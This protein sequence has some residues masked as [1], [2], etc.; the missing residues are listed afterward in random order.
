MR[1]VLR[2]IP[3]RS[4][5][6]A[7][8]CSIA[9]GGPRPDHPVVFVGDRLGVPEPRGDRTRERRRQFRRPA[10]PQV[11]RPLTGPARRGGRSGELRVEVL[12]VAVASRSRSP[13]DRGRV[14]DRLQVFPNLGEQRDG[15]SP[16]PSWCSVWGAHRQAG[17]PVHVRPPQRPGDLA[18]DAPAEPGQRDQQPPF[19]IGAASI[20][21]VIASRGRTPCGPG[22]SA[23]RLSP[24]SAGSRQE[25][26]PAPPRAKIARAVLIRLLIVAGAAGLTIA[27]RQ[28]SASSDHARQRTLGP[29]PLLQRG[30][31]LRVGAIRVPG[32]TFSVAVVVQQP[33]QRRRLRRAGS[34][35]SRPGVHMRSGRSASHRALPRRS[36]FR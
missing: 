11:V 36:P 21:L 29:E 27:A 10:R 14:E 4:A 8:P 12:P 24:R 23:S 5:R 17:A 35:T 15:R 2:R 13:I 6:F 34:A 32:F 22:S 18:R 1:T 20:T 16:L 28:R 3:R 19:G 26:P 25:H 31:R 9:R 33:T 30:P 7:P